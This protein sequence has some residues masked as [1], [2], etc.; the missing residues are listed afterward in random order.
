MERLNL[1][2]LNEVEGKEQH[3]VKI[4][5]RFPGFESSGDD[6]STEIANHKETFKNVGQRETTL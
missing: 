3:R 2:K 4:S 1:M 6:V 5:K